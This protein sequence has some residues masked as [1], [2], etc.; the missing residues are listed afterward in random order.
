M[1]V[2]TK[3]PEKLEKGKNEK[4]KIKY[5]E[6]NSLLSPKKSTNWSS[7]HV[8]QVTSSSQ[9]KALAYTYDVPLNIDIVI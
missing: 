6:W 9:V 2:V 1:K 5:G 4:E 7:D 3:S 8:V